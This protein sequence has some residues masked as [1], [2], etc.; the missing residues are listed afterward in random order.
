MTLVINPSLSLSITWAVPS[1]Y[2][3]NSLVLPSAYVV[4]V[5]PEVL[6]SVLTFVFIWTWLSP[7]YFVSSIFLLPSGLVT[8][9]E[10]LPSGFVTVVVLLPSVPSLICVSFPVGLVITVT[11][12]PDSSV[13]LFTVPS[14][15]VVVVEP[16]FSTICVPSGCVVVFTPSSITV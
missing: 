8:T 4:N 6:P 1:S 5:V 12:L 9:F 10:T 11:L 13:S 15:Y 3:V 16:S 14:G 7:T 2:S